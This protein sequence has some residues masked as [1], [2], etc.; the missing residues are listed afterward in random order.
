MKGA[1]H[2]ALEQLHAIGALKIEIEQHQVDRRFRQPR[3]RL[4][5]MGGVDHRLQGGAQDLAAHPL[6]ALRNQGLVF[7]D[8]QSHG[9]QA[10][11]RTSITVS[12]PAA[13]KPSRKLQRPGKLSSS[14][15]LT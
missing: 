8:Q 2:A 10:V 12:H 7:N 5:G 13:V 15:A 4:L 3:G 11:S 14:R 9:V 6:Q 1:R